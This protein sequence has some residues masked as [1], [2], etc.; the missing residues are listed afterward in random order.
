MTDPAPDTSELPNRPPSMLDG[1]PRWLVTVIN[2][3]RG[4]AIGAS[5]T[6]PGIS[7]GTT[8]LIIGLYDDLIAGAGHI[9]HGAKNLVVDLPRRAGTARARAEWRQAKWGI[10]VPVL[11]GMGIALI[12]S[13]KLL[14]PL[15]ERHP[16]YALA[17]FFGLVLASLPIPY[18]HSG[19]P[20][21]LRHYLT[22]LVAAVA[23]FLFTGL[24]QANLPQHPVV[25]FLAA[26]V[27]VCA[28]VLPGLSGSFILLMVGLY[29][30]TLRAV[31]D[32]NL[33]YLGI[34]ALG[35]VVGMASVVQL[36]QFLLKHH[37]HLTTVVLTGL[38][39]G[40][41]R[42]LWPWQDEARGFVA[43]TDIGLTVVCA[44]I[45]FV[46]VSGFILL[47]RRAAARS[48]TR[49]GAPSGA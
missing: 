49:A 32:A 37:H 7:G 43:P 34:F 13:A 11:I 41:L 39:A 33:G 10:I 20:W 21:K 47:G 3:I 28:L 42:A 17:V 29:E 16:Q 44:V 15:V 24:P 22:A 26:A 36:M 45:G 23:S 6:L 38:M 14:A 40:S 12:L 35:M 25:I 31:A 2:L 5:E 18:S 30:P 19:Q 1:L 4:G 9:I 46:V 27:A 8:A 48:G